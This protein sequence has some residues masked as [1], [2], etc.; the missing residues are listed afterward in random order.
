M[1]KSSNSKGF[2]G[3]VTVTPQGVT[4]EID[5]YKAHTFLTHPV[6]G[7]SDPLVEAYISFAQRIRAYR[8]SIP[9]A[10][11]NPSK[12]PRYYAVTMCEKENEPGLTDSSQ[13]KGRRWACNT[14]FSF[15]PCVWTDGPTPE[16][17]EQE[18]EWADWAAKQGPSSH[19]IKTRKMIF[20]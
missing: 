12:G 5:S 8:T 18:Q 15:A 10:A 2:W 9:T 20:R 19:A 17:E 4:E 3:G 13:P 14:C 11:G 16:R 7:A 6:E 1:K